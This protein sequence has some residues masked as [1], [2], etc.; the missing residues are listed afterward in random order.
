VRKA[1]WDYIHLRHFLDHWFPGGRST[2]EIYRG[3]GAVGRPVERHVIA[4]ADVQSVLDALTYAI[5]RL[6]PED[7]Q[8]V[9]AYYVKR[10]GSSAAGQLGI[11]R[12]TMY[13]R[14]DVISAEMAV[15]LSAMDMRAWRAFR[16]FARAVLERDETEP[17]LDSETVKG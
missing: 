16:R 1:L 2:A 12:A 4:R 6:S 9:Q 15:V 5:S 3:T 10:R 13:R 11:S 14:L 8:L 7:R 17:G